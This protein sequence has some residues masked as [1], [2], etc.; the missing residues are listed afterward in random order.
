MRIGVARTAVARPALQLR[1]VDPR[2]ADVAEQVA[3]AQARQRAVAD[4]HAA[5]DRAP[6]VAVGARDDGRDVAGRAL[7]RRVARVP[8]E[9]APAEV[10]A[11]DPCRGGRSRSPRPRPGRRRRSTRSP[12]AAVE[13]EAPR[14]A[15]PVAVDLAARAIAAAERVVAGHGVG[16]AGRTAAGRCAGS[17]RAASRG[18]ARCRARRARR[19]RR[20]R[21]RCRCRGGLS[22]PNSSRPPL[23]LPS[24]SCMRSTR[25]AEPASARLALARWYS[26]TRWSPELVGEV[27]VEAAGAGVVGREGDRQQALLAAGLTWPRMSRKACA[28]AR[29]PRP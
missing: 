4:D 11:A 5:G 1:R 6:A 14:V 2:L 13:R 15:Q 24:L 3:P 10:R 26:T 22:G 29:R 28:C 16:A 18:S 9:R 12:R 8:L 7:A 27:D 20:R 19:P 25:R 23:W 21:R 17:C